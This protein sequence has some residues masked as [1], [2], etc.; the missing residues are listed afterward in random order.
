[1][2]NADRPSADAARATCG[3]CQYPAKPLPYDP[4]KGPRGQ[5]APGPGLGSQSRNLGKAGTQGKH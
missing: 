5:Y 3:G 2:A 4:P 1:M